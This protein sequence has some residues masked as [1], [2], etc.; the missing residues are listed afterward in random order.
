MANERTLSII[1]PD[2]T[3]R[4]LTGEI[5][6]RFEAAGLRIIAQ[7]RMR[8]SRAQ[9][10]RFYA[11]HKERPF[12]DGLCGFMA[13]GPVVVQVLEGDNA[14]ARNLMQQHGLHEMLK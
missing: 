4:N 11:V 14:I 3:Q 7:K 2:A 12:F 13:S 9:T 10:E 5:C 8:L 6:A 1:K